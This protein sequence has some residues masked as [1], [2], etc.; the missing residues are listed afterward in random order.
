MYI[1][2]L[3][4][5][6]ADD[7][8]YVYYNV[9]TEGFD[10]SLIKTKVYNWSDTV[11][12]TILNNDSSVITFDDDTTRLYRSIIL[13]ENKNIIGFAPPNSITYERFTE[14]KENVTSEIY[15]NE[16]IEGTMLNLFYDA[17]IQS[18][19]LS[20]RGAVGANYWYYRNQYGTTEEAATQ[21]TFRD[22]FIEC[23]HVE[24][25]T[26]M[27]SIPLIQSLPKNYCYSFVLQHP[28]NHI[29]MTVLEPTIYLVAVYEKSERRVTNIPQVVYETWDVFEQFTNIVKFPASFSEQT[30]N[31]Y[32]S[33]YCSIHSNYKFMGIMFTN[34]KTGYRMAMWNIAYEEVKKLRGNN[35]NLQFQFFT[36]EK[37]MQTDFFLYYFPMYKPLFE[38]FSRQYQ[39]F[40]THVHQSY[41]S[42]YVKKDRVP[43]AKK[44]FIHASKIHH[45]IFIPSM[46]E[47]NRKIITRM[48]VKGYFDALTPSEL[49]YYL[50]YDQKQLLKVKNTEAV[51]TP[52]SSGSPT[53]E[54]FASV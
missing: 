52:E 30:Y 45:N 40:I 44:Y 43:I 4:R 10:A 2:Y 9:D 6:D 34:L 7:Y 37:A 24:K 26:D 19:Q 47:G 32:Q 46:N 36:L 18:W 29:V 51:E 21:K 15:A 11:A 28:D 48:V 38:D 12:Y 16:I 53:S 33:K 50:N 25:G 31:D 42:Y 1:S 41:F 14:N 3:K 54:V 17:R 22:M 5:M 23:F 39:D 8:K 13:D 20:T 49:L 35:T 27:N